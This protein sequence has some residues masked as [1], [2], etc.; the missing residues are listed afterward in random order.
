M[1]RRERGDQPVP[2]SGPDLTAPPD[3]NA[4][5]GETS[6]WQI[7]SKRVGADGTLHP[8]GVTNPNSSNYDEVAANDIHRPWQPC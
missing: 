6:V 1:G 3:P 8:S 7:G 5:S 4:A 2:S